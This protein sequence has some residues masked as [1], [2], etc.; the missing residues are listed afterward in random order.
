[1]SVTCVVVGRKGALLTVLR[2]PGL[3]VQMAETVCA[4]LWVLQAK[5]RT[6]LRGLERAREE[7]AMAT[8]QKE[9]KRPKEAAMLG[10]ILADIV[11]TSAG[12]P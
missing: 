5:I 12:A 11:H 7:D 9:I 6:Q 4:V 10:I 2:N 8:L 3:A 1:M